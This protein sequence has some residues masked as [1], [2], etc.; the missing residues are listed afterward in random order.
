MKGHRIFLT[1]GAGFIGSHLVA[2]LADD[3]QVTVFDT[4]D[5]DALCRTRYAGHHN[6]HLVQ[7]DVLDGPAVLRAMSGHDTVVHLAAIA[8]I[9]TVIKSPTRTMRVNIEGT[10]RVLE[11]AVQNR[12]AHRFLNFST[13]EVFGAYT[14]RSS[15]SDSTQAGAVGGAR[16]TYAVAKLAAEH[17]VNSYGREFGLPTVSVRPFNIYGPGQIGE[18]AIHHFV[19]R[20]LRNQEIQIHG[21]GD[22][23]RSW[24]YIDDIVDCLLLCLT[25]DEAVGQVFNIG[26]PRGTVTIYGLALAVLRVCHS[27]S[28]IRFVPREHED[29]ELRVPSIA[30]AQELLGY[31]PKVDLE[32]GLRRTADWYWQEIQRERASAAVA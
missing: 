19:A 2:R 7:G 1:G 32:E 31:S 8:G 13:S 18:G 20:A 16:W 28:T 6:V 9:D 25:S 12:V 14:Y 26:N 27:S 21:D 5:R 10:Q 3:N 23:I 30:K 11:A 15:E 24:C 4:F 22:Q 17:L 29:V